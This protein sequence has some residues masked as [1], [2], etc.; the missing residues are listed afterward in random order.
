[1]HSKP[2]S[3]GHI[4]RPLLVAV[5]QIFTLASLFNSPVSADPVLT[6]GLLEEPKTLNVWGASDGWSRKVLGRIC[7]PLY[8]REPKTLNLIPWLAQGEPLF[9]EAQL[10]YTIRLRPAKWSDGSAFTSEDVAF[11][12]NT[13]KEFKVPRYYANW[14]FIKKTEAID[15]H[16]VRFFLERPA[17]I[18]LGRTLTTPIVQ[19]KEWEKVIPKVR[20]A[21]KPLAELLKHKVKRP[22]STGPFVL[23]KWRKG[24]YLFLTKNKYFFGQDREVG[25]H[26]LGPHIDGIILKVFGTTDAAILALRKGTIDM[27]WWGLQPGYLEDLREDSNIKIFSTEKSSLYFLGFNVRKRPFNDVH[28]RRAVATLIDKDFIIKRILQGYATKMHSIV[29]PGNRFWHC[30]ELPKYGEGLSRKARIQKAYKILKKA[31]YTWESPPVDASGKISKGED[32]IMPDGEPMDRITILT[33][34]ADYDPHRAMTGIMVQEWLK[35]V[36]IPAS[37]RSMAFGALFHQV[38][39]RHEFDLFILGYGQLSLDPDYLRNFFHSGSDRPRGWNMSGYSNPAFDRIAE[40]SGGALD[41]EKRR[42]LIWKMQKM[43]MEDV[44][45]V[46]LYNPKHIEAVRRDKFEGWVQMLGGI[47]NTWS[48]CQIRPK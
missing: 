40:D 48:F 42:K 25:G 34:P 31:K 43:I 28:F 9:D 24:A 35:E 5:F 39:T 3:F 19:K 37:S 18:F 20:K 11:T 38:R 27:F 44:P 47:G 33:P 26:R 13:I 1:M 41:P 15:K 10:S 12:G 16:T 23:T 7:H 36:G 21:K 46:P 14:R 22:V 45:Y 8:I 30:P 4:C 2:K 32:I 17:A 29:P 6:I